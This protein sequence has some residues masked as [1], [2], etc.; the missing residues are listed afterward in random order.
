MQ[1]SISP[2]SISER[3]E[4][5][6]EIDDETHAAASISNEVVGQARRRA[7]G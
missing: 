2:D 1:T 4:E 5:E 3:E 6:E 7:R